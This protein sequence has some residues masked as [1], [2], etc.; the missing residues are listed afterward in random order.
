MSLFS[1]ELVL[2]V[3]LGDNAASNSDWTD[4]DSEEFDEESLIRY[5][6]DRGFSYEEI[7]LLLAKRHHHEISYSTL[8]RRLSAYGLKRRDFFKNPRRDGIIEEARR[9]ITSLISGP[10]SCCGYRSLWHTLEIEGLRVPR[11]VVQDIIK[12]LDPEGSKLRKAHCLKRRKY[13]NPGPNFAWHQDGYDKLKPYGFPIHGCIDGFS[14]KILWLS[15][16]RSNNSPDNIA[17]FYLNTVRELKGCPVELITDLGTEN[18]LSASIQSY[19]RDNA[20]AHRYVSSPRNQRIESWWSF[21]SKNRSKWWRN[22]FQDLESQGLIDSTSQLRRECLWYCFSGILQ[23]DLDAIKEQ[24]N[25]HL[26]RK[27]RF[28]TVSGRPDVLFYLPEQFGAM[29]NLLIEV[30]D[31]EINYVSQ[32]IVQDT[33]VSEEEEYF[34]YACAILNLK[35][36]DDW[37]EAYETY[38]KLMDVA[39]N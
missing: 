25:T 17:S 38:I 16:T 34:D 29:S 35:K 19:F 32:H 3:T 2:D 23:N 36:P 9:R 37:Q 24:W 6:F 10:S 8:L 31:R 5:Y 14:R 20:D 1:L 21:Y 13:H 39:E 7:C 30:P 11:I 28:D 15:V 4:S 33:V 22:F 12:E 26:I 27:S 18:G